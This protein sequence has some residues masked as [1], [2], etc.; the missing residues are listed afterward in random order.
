M[1]IFD[2]STET[3]NSTILTLEVNLLTIKEMG[4]HWH[5]Y[6]L[7]NLHLISSILVVSDSDCSEY[8]RSNPSSS[9]EQFAVEFVHL[10]SFVGTEF[11][12]LSVGRHFELVFTIIAGLGHLFNQPLSNFIQVMD[13][14]V[15]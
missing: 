14:V 13:D 2:I 15:V 11:I 8:S 10:L 12:V 3:A 9:F 6:L 4:E 5:S 7:I 1:D